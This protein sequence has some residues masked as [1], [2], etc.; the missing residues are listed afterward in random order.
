MSSISKNGLSD[1][2]GGVT[3]VK[4]LKIITGLRVNLESINILN[5]AKKYYEKENP[6]KEELEKIRL[7]CSNPIYD[8]VIPLSENE[9]K[10]LEESYYNFTNDFK[11]S[12]LNKMTNIYQLQSPQG[13]SNKKS[14][15]NTNDSRLE[16]II[17]SYNKKIN[18]YNAS[19]NNNLFINRLKN[20]KS[21]QNY[22]NILQESSNSK[23]SGLPPVM[24]SSQINTNNSGYQM[25]TSRSSEDFRPPINYN[26]I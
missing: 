23:T 26:G 8:L 21:I 4:I 5:I 7:I 22:L 24:E 15:F 20:S 13:I 12:T 3:E 17:N 9:E 18:N 6:S 25:N 16:E 1:I 2:I 10:Y 14:N 19:S 11:G